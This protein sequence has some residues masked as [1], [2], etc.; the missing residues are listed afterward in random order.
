MVLLFDCFAENTPNS[1]P[2]KKLKN[3]E[4]EVDEKEDEKSEKMETDVTADDYV[5]EHNENN[6]PET[7]QEVKQE[8]EVWKMLFFLCAADFLLLM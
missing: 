6:T 5:T 4:G 7:P 1:A 8:E 2:V 3:D